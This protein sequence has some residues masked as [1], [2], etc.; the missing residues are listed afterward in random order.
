VNGFTLNDQGA[1]LWIELIEPSSEDYTEG[2]VKYLVRINPSLNYDFFTEQFFPERRIFSIPLTPLVINKGESRE[3]IK[4]KL[5]FKIT[6]SSFY[7]F[8]DFISK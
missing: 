5:E 2:T 1:A 6:G 3:T 4:E 8:E 7:Y